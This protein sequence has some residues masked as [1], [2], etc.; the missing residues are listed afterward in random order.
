MFSDKTDDRYGYFAS[1]NFYVICEDP[2]LMTSVFY[3]LRHKDSMLSYV[4][5]FG[6]HSVTRIKDVSLGYDS[7]TDEIPRDKAVSPSGEMI[8]FEL[9]GS[10]VMTL[11]GSGTEPKLKYYIESKGEKMAHVMAKAEDVERALNEVFREFGLNT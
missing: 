7:K 4:K 1:R 6:E 3:K 10:T 8:T 2:T 11:R 5:R 9:D